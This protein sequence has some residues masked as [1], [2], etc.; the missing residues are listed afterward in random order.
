MVWFNTMNQIT[1]RLSHK[2]ENVNGGK[3]A[4]K[5]VISPYAIK[6]KLLL[7]LQV[8]LVF[9]VN[10]LEPSA[11]DPPHPC[12]VQSPSYS[13]KVDRQI[14]YKVS[15][16]VDSCLFGRAKRLQYCVQWTSYRKLSWEYAENITH[17]TDLLH[18]FHTYYLRKLRPLPQ[19]YLMLTEC[20][21]RQRVVLRVSLC[22]LKS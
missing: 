5:R 12:H 14:E 4:I 1:T 2:L 21:S 16:I 7:D 9:N 20:T 22:T 17:T 11:I 19:P 13:L 18:D 15:D 3:Y 8:H 10:L 6:L